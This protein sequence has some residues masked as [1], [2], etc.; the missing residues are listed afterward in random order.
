MKTF[1]LSITLLAFAL[2]PASGQ[3]N[4]RGS[5]TGPTT[6]KGYN[7]PN[8]YLGMKTTQLA[9]NME[10]VMVHPPQ[11]QEAMKKL[12]E[13]EKKFGKKPN[14]LIF[15]LDDV[16]WMDPGFNGG[17]EA[18]GNPTP[19]LDKI[20]HQGL[21]LTSAYSTPSCT[22]TR[23]TIMTGQTP[24]HHGLLRPPMY[25][26]P[27]GLDGSITLPMILHELGYKTQ[28]VGKWHLGENEGSQPQNVGFD[29][30]YGFLSVS[31][32]YTEWR[33]LYF[34]PEIVLSPTRFAVLEKFPFNHDNVHCTKEKGLENVYLIDLETIKNLDQDWADY[35]EKFI[36]SQQDSDQ[37]WF[38]YHATR[39]CHF[40]NYPNDTYAGK[41]PARTVFSDGMVEIDDVFGRLVKVLEETGQLD[42]TIIFF[43]SDNGPEAEVP[44]HGRTPFRG[45]KGSSWEGGVRVP[46]FVYWKGIIPAKKSDGLFDL[47]D[48]FNTCLSIAGMKS[49]DLSKRVGEKRYIDGVDQ[50]S[51]WLANEGQS[52]RYSRIYTLNQYLSA[53]RVDEFKLHATVELQKAIFPRGFTGGFSGAIV[54][55]AG[56]TMVNLYTDPQEDIS[57]GIRHIPAAVMVGAELDRY[58]AVL[59]KFPPQMKIGFMSN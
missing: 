44:P 54:N 30:Y 3:T 41:S 58:A 14:I 38:L 18:V 2:F 35:S 31:D 34:N 10:P 21:I 16:G 37:P 8:Q 48:L 24:L 55:T 53:V 4:L 1:L 17:G 9:E 51:F 32:M 13:M 56:A 40:D 42:N 57:I 43:T 47:G 36:R 45:S 26:E 5:T 52:N 50:T 20:A 28:G 12:Q 15:I 33:D 7:H 6:A 25:G 46:T 39:A 59:Q 27:G 11:D 22:P 29:D 49:T 23:A 19:N